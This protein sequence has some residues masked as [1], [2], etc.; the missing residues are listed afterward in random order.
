MTSSGKFV[1]AR[2]TSDQA[3][4][5]PGERRR[6]L[7]RAIW[8]LIA[9]LVVCG[10]AWVLFFHKGGEAAGGNNQ[11]GA[12]KGG[13]HGGAP[14]T[15]PTA[16][17][18]AQKG[19]VGV[20]LTALGTVTP[21]ATVTVHT[22]IAGL[23]MQL[24]FT[25]GQMVRKG[26]FLAQV[27]PRP[28]EAQLAQYEGQLAKD[29]AALADAQLD[30]KR[31]Q[32]LVKQD[33]LATQTLDTQ[34][35]V[36]HQDQGTVKT[37]QAQVN[38]AKLNLVYC[39]ITSPATGRVGLR[40]VDVGNYVQTS[41]ANGIVIITQL[42]PMSVIFVLPEDNIDQVVKGIRD[43]GKLKVTALDRS[44]SGAIA[45]GELETLDN[46]IDTTTGTVK[47][48]ALFDNKD[49][50][51]FPNQFV[52]I[53]LLTS[54]LHDTIVIPTAAIQRGAP[55]TFVYL[56]KPDNTVTVKV[57]KPGPIDGQNVA[58][59]DGLS[60][61]DKVV[62]DGADKL[63]EGA[64]ISIPAEQKPGEGKPAD[65]KP[66]DKDAAAS[67]YGDSAGNNDTSGAHKGHHH[68]HAQPAPAQ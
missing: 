49:L 14:G 19:D 38:T 65:G 64:K 47:L 35:A 34:A 6:G 43:S 9:V 36:V 26:D 51:L 39:H 4:Q 42:Q 8:T 3:P 23:L 18:V 52:N 29:Q 30:L 27:D 50:A 15:M 5:D 41:D 33:S 57:I 66:G 62:V 61:G 40:Q 21:L 31:Y 45:T 20:T 2:P 54:T 13:R 60:Q 68:D 1:G 25:E 58:V 7:R 28:Y 56:V 55:G 37:D 48:R 46:Q 17:A 53:N 24:G 10:L 11:A 59:L 67:A 32:M 16:V 22:Q 12:A 63:K 44:N